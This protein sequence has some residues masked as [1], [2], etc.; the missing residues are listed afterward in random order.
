M[1]TK[2]FNGTTLIVNHP[3]LVRH[4]AGATTRKLQEWR[5]SAI[6]LAS[7][8]RDGTVDG[9]CGNLEA[10]RAKQWRRLFTPRHAQGLRQ[11]C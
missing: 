2:F 1:K 9:E 6:D 4:V 5:G 11:D 7:I 3:G 10:D 8:L